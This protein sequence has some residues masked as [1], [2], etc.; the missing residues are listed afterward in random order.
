MNKFSKC[1]DID[2]Y[3]AVSKNVSF[4]VRLKVVTNVYRPV[5]AIVRGQMFW[6]II[7]ELDNEL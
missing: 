6:P 7:H 3:E 4:N 5:R 2:L 1:T